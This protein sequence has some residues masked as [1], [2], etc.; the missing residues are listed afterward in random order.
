[1][2]TCLDWHIF[3]V[4]NEG[5]PLA[6]EEPF[7]KSIVKA[8]LLLDN[9]DA[10][11]KIFGEKMKFGSPKEV[12]MFAETHGFDYIAVRQQLDIPSELYIVP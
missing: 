6:C 4:L 10:T 5:Q 11:Q 2:T 3:T 7:G 8:L 9:E 12:R 1:M